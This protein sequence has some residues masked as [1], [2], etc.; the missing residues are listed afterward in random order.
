MPNRSNEIS[1]IVKAED[2]FFT[3]PDFITYAKD[4]YMDI[5]NAWCKR[6]LSS[7]QAVLHSNLYDRTQKQ[8]DKKIADGIVP[9]L[10][11]ITVEEAYLTFYKKDAEYEYVTVYLS[12]KMI[13]YQTQES[14]G[15]ILYGDMT[16]RW[17]LHYLMTFMR[18]NNVKTPE[19]GSAKRAFNC[20]NCGGV[21]DSINF[22]TCPYCGSIVKSGEYG[23]VLSDFNAVRD[24]TTDQGIQK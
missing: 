2:E 15:N 17:E 9:H 20:P 16:T 5:Q 6:D 21:M 3:E 8:L 4:V 24:N 12:S 7:V 10:D 18:S 11:R 22:G 23:W 1:A 13:D 14:T 19:A